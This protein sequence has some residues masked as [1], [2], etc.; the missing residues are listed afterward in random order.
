MS[1]QEFVQK[2]PCTPGSNWNLEMLAYKERVNWSTR[3]KNS[4]RRAENQQQTRPTY[5]AGS[6]NQTQDTLM[7]GKRSHHC[8]IPIS[9]LE[10]FTCSWRVSNDD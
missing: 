3:K 6:W 7:G 10:P 1:S 9:V 4:Q 2:C 5:D 8:A